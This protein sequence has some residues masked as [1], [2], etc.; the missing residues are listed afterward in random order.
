IGFSIFA[1][2]LRREIGR[3]GSYTIL[4]ED[5]G[6]DVAI[7]FS[8]YADAIVDAGIAPAERRRLFVPLGSDPA[9]AAARR[10]EGWVTVAALDA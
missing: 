3:G 6:E 9:L 7:G 5:G 8:L 10:A 2:G 1:G 4:R